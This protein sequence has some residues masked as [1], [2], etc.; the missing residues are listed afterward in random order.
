VFKKDDK[1]IVYVK[2]GSAFAPREVKVVSEA[3]GR[4]QIEGL[5]ENTEVA[6]VN[7]EERARKSSDTAGENAIGGGG[8]T[9]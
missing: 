8:G 4:V 1:R 3:E 2:N 9:P 6:L 7:P 5:K